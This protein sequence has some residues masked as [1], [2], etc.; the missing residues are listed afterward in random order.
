[1]MGGLL[2]TGKLTLG[3][4]LHVQRVCLAKAVD[5]PVCIVE[6][7]RESFAG[8]VGQDDGVGV[9]AGVESGD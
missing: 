8:V 9:A 1:M 4:R 3:G 5:G 2:L 6:L 7:A